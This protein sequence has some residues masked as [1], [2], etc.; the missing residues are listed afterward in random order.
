MEQKL[1]NLSK[2]IKTL[3][4]AYN[5]CDS[6]ISCFNILKEHVSQSLF[7]SAIISYYSILKSRTEKEWLLNLLQNPTDIKIIRLR[8]DLRILNG[9]PLH[10]GIKKIFEKYEK[11]RDKNIA[12]KDEKRIKEQGKAWLKIPQGIGGGDDLP[13]IHF[14]LESAFISLP[15]V[16]QRE[17]LTLIEVTLDLWWRKENLPINKKNPDKTFKKVPQPNPIN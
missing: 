12:H 15:I 14:V 5:L 8:R 10:E 13:G 17:F 4:L 3:L 11:I 16:E 2:E 9:L 6:A 1:L 7:H